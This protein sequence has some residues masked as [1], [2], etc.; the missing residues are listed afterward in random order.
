MHVTPSSQNFAKGQVMG[1]D[2][3]SVQLHENRVMLSEYEQN[4]LK[5]REELSSRLVNL[6]QDV[7]PPLLHNHN[8]RR[9]QS[10]ITGILLL[11]YD[12]LTSKTCML[13]GRWGHIL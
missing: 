12:V 5:A 11:R 3:A 8:N 9:K 6:D 2:D 4:L 1:E 10:Q 7:T 13:F